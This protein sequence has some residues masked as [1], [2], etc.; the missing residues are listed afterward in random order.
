MHYSK[1]KT[2]LL[3]LM[4]GTAI[5]AAVLTNVTATTTVP[6]G[7]TTTGVNLTQS[8][9]YNITGSNGW[10]QYYYPD[11]FTNA[12][13]ATPVGGTIAV[14]FVGFY[15]YNDLFSGDLGYYALF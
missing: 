11:Y 4:L 14:Q 1:I 5:I 13:V 8:W 9:I 2:L 12:Y 10:V 6:T 7:Y 3:S 15:D